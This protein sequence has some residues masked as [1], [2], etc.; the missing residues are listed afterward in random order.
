MQYVVDPVTLNVID[1]LP[2]EPPLPAPP[3]LDPP[4]PGFDSIT[5]CPFTHFVAAHM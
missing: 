2:G 1:T 4:A 5:H 3:E